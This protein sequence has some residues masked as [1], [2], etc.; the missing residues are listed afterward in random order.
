MAFLILIALGACMVFTNP[1][2]ADFVSW[3]EKRLAGQSGNVLAEAGAALAA[4]AI[5]AATKV[6]DLKVCSLF[7][8]EILGEK[9]VALGIL[10]F[11]I[12]LR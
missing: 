2:K 3:T 10:G 4:P 8:T 5:G 9:H 1:D 6:R 12:K 7:E 11:F